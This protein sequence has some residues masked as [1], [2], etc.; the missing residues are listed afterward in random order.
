MLLYK[1][2]TIFNKLYSAYILLGT[3]L[4]FGNRAL[5]FDFQLWKWCHSMRHY[6]QW[7]PWVGSTF[8]LVQWCGFV[9]LYAAHRHTSQG[10][11]L[12]I[13]AIKRCIN[14]TNHVSFLFKNKQFFLVEIAIRHLPASW[15]ILVH[16]LR[17]LH[18]VMW[19]TFAHTPQLISVWYAL[20]VIYLTVW[21][22]IAYFM[23]L[24]WVV[25]QILPASWRFLK[26]R[27][28]W[29]TAVP[30]KSRKA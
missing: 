24:L 11:Q 23:T 2:G 13:F 29:G 7:L 22:I 14:I 20:I 18:Y 26:K 15:I 8:Q 30:Q 4:A 19:L 10:T 21:K 5:V 9:V 1:K 12:A 3:H 16:N 6:K 28:L 17:V 27:Y 25:P